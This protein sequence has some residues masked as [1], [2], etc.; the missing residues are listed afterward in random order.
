MSRPESIATNPP[1]TAQPATAKKRILIFIVAYN[2]Q[3]TL[4]EVI[5]RIA[6]DDRTN[7]VDVLIIDDASRD[8]TFEVGLSLRERCKYPLTVLQNPTN[9]GYGGNQKLGYHY[10]IAHGYDAVA[11][12]HGDGQYAPEKLQDLV[13]PVIRG[14]ADAVFG[15]RMMIRGGALRGGMPL[16]KF[17]GNKILT[18]L[19]NRILGLELSEFHSGYRV[20]SVAALGRIPFEYN[21][22]DFHFDTEI[23][24]Q[25]LAAHQ[26][27]LEVPIP[28][29]YGDEIS[30]VDGLAYAYQVV[31]ST[32]AYWLHQKGVFYRYNFDVGDAGYELKGGYR[33][34][35]TLAID[36]VPAGSLVVDVGC[37]PGFVG[38][39][40]SRD[41]QC[42]VIGIDRLE[43]SSPA[44][45]EYHRLDLEVDR[46]PRCFGRADVVLLLDVLET[47]PNPEEFL[48]HLRQRIAA[49][50]CRLMI[51]T[52]NIGFV[53]LR[54]MLL[55]GQFNYGKRGI[56]DKKH[57]RLF[58]VG[59]LRR[60][61][62]QA[63]FVV[64][65]VEGIPAPF[66]KALGDNHLGRLLLLA[67]RWAIAVS[68]RLFAYQIFLEA[69][70]LATVETLVA[71]TERHSSQP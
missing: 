39:I 21:A 64:Q 49:G 33:S 69:T 12:L 58:T 32:L 37:G 65:G 38:E 3:K 50:S 71:E 43:E 68:K 25:L 22:N 41:K 5:N 61:L 20:Y 36:K 45:A 11:L 56:L 2:A 67:N 10:A 18:T 28:T 17:V 26:R 70:A 59:S 15:S 62:T 30:H 35:H 19:Q 44:L 63:G 53:I 57:K 55:F 42:R 6:I 46:L 54:L 60:L 31:R 51:T 27:I 1:G 23:I 16:Y 8:A 29:F 47:L 9:Q 4:A 13:E 48:F 14:R 66:P 24:I 40:L 7:Q 52:P 34:S